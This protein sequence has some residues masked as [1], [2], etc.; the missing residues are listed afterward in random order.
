MLSEFFVL[1]FF[2]HIYKCNDIWISILHLPKYLD[3]D[4]NDLLPDSFTWLLK[5]IIFL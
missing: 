5:G 4:Y 3:I 1:L 2:F